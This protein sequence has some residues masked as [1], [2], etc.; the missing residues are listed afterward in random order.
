[1]QLAA[2]AGVAQGTVVSVENGRKVRPG[3]LKAVLDALEV[4]V[5][6]EDTSP[7]ESVQLALDLVSKWLMAMEPAQ[8]SHAVNDLVRFTMLGQTSRST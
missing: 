2:E 1:M 5:A 3:N 4:T 7:D 6:S 8:R